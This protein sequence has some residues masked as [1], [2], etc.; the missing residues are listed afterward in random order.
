MSDFTPNQLVEIQSLKSHLSSGYK[1]TF[2]KVKD[3]ILLSIQINPV[4]TLFVTIQPYSVSS[5][6]GIGNSKFGLFLGHLAS[7][8]FPSD[9]RTQLAFQVEHFL[10][11]TI[12]KST[13]E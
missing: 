9:F 8:Y 2:N 1:W 11:K 5:R 12:Q 4:F 6:W 10:Q 3:S 7:R 13:Q